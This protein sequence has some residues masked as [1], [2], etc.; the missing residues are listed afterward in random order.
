MDFLTRQETQVD[1]SLVSFSTFTSAQVQ[2]WI[3]FSY[4]LFIDFLTFLDFLTREDSTRDSRLET[5]DARRK[6]TRQDKTRPQSLLHHF[7]K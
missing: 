5:Q 1:N 6:S 4:L 2:V 7:I 3:L